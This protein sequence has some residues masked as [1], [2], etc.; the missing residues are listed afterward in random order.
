MNAD[1]WYRCGAIIYSPVVCLLLLLFS[2]SF[3]A[4]VYSI[5]HT[6]S[7][8]NNHRCHH[9]HRRPGQHGV[10]GQ[11]SLSYRPLK[12]IYVYRPTADSNQ[13]Y[14]T[15][16]TGVDGHRWM[17][18]VRGITEII[19]NCCPLPFSWIKIAYFPIHWT[20]FLFLFRS[21]SFFIDV[22]TQTT[23]TTRRSE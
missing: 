3:V 5:L 2:I 19:L 13:L 18:E 9:R 15:R 22:H 1:G 21:L 4:K 11:L 16:S 8:H 12:Y 7:A 23:T 20:S 17:V 14:T 6:P 10:R